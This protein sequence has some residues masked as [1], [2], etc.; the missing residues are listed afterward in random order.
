MAQ[1]RLRNG[2]RVDP[3]TEDGANKGEASG[4]SDR[5][6]RGVQQAVVGSNPTSGSR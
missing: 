4:F 2:W 1:V 6:P 5:W 3:G